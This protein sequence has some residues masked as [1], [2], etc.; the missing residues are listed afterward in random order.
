MLLQQLNGLH[1]EVLHTHGSIALAEAPCTSL[2]VCLNGSDVRGFLS[3]W[4][5]F[6]VRL[7]VFRILFCKYRSA[8]VFTNVARP[9]SAG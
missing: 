3:S 6:A 1:Y 8:V 5:S 2:I 4:M 9:P 7:D